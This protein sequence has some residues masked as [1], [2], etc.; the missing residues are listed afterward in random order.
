MFT[1]FLEE[2][3][4][5]ILS[6][7]HDFFTY[8]KS[9]A[10]NS[11]GLDAITRLEEYCSGGKM[12]RGSLVFLG[13]LIAGGN[14]NPDLIKIASAMELIQAGLLI[15]DDIMDHDELR[16]GKP[17]MHSQYEQ[18]FLKHAIEFPK[19][20]AQSFAICTGD[21]AFFYAY[22]LLGSVSTAHC[23]QQASLCL[24]KVVQAQMQ[25]VY[26]GVSEKPISSEKIILSLY[27]NK[28]GGYSISLPLTLG[29]MAG[30]ASKETLRHI[31]IFGKNIGIVFQLI[32]D[33]LNLFGNS[34]TTG[35]S[36]GS[37]ITEGKKTL[38]H[39][40]LSRTKPGRDLLKTK[41]VDRIKAY[42]LE[43]GIDAQ[44]TIYIEQYIQGAKEVIFHIPIPGKIKEIVTD[45]IGYVTNRTK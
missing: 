29:A 7:L 3:K 37:D 19:D 45:F 41:N 24:S 39:Y 12:I 4:K 26:Q 30:N 21:M 36:T 10:I 25:D 28:T 33:R 43:S 8:Q 15:H 32:D 35:K 16:R 38:Y 2:N 6:S 18:L 9:Q 31:Q 17:S 5:N 44:I 13:H 1:T 22:E 11:W 40:L 42:C 14:V 20:S 23:A 27:Q 34:T